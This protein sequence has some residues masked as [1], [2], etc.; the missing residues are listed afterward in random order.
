M[1]KVKEDVP[2]VSDQDILLSLSGRNTKAR[3]RVEKEITRRIKELKKEAGLES[4]INEALE[5]KFTQK[6][7]NAAEPS[8]RILKLMKLLASLRAQA[9]LNIKNDAQLKRVIE[10]IQKVEDAL[11]Q[12]IRKVNEKRKAQTRKDVDFA[13]ALLDDLRRQQAEEAKIADLE[14]IEAGLATEIKQAPQRKTGSAELKALQ[15]RREEVQTEIATR[16][17]LQET[18]DAMTVQLGENPDQKREKGEPLIES[19]LVTALREQI[20]QLKQD[21]TLEGIKKKIKDLETGVKAKAKPKKVERLDIQLAREEFAK[22]TRLTRVEESVIDLKLQ[23]KTGDIKISAP[24]EKEVLSE[25]LQKALIEQKQL[26]RKV[27]ARI[28][29]LAP[30]TAAGLAIDILLTS[31]QL[32][33]TADMSFALRQGLI[34]S[35]RRPVLATK[36]FGRA[37]RAFFSQNTADSI[38]IA[39]KRNPNQF[40]RDKADLFL[41]DIDLG[42]TGREEEFMGRLLANVPVIGSILRASERNMATGLNLLRSAVFDDFIT[43]HPEATAEQRKAYADYINKATGRGSLEEWKISGQLLQAIFFAPRFAVSRIQA[44]LAIVKNFKDPLVRNEIIKDFAALVLTASTIMMLAK[45]AGADVGLD[46][47]DSDFGKI[48]I[49]DTRIDILGGLVQPARVVSL[50]FL[51]TYQIFDKPAKPAKRELREDLKN[52]FWYKTSPAVGI[53]VTLIDEENAIGQ[54]QT[55]A[56]TAL[57]AITPLWVQETYEVAENSKD[58]LKAALAA[59]AAGTGIGISEQ[60]GRKK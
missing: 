9:M 55:A 4:Q 27:N 30:K 57:R 39:I 38:D 50:A 23:L 42:V 28:A 43:K 40:E 26:R 41:S 49:G 53:I 59:L 19:M 45:G 11:N 37:F 48:V 12:N 44:P 36:T 52:F 35:A 60:A 47:D 56:E 32:L 29:G 25:D 3:K 34:L 33:A 46:P 17:Q 31:R 2:D 58:T 24:R 51:K 16:R 15:V 18:I 54:E 1:A 14:A 21:K 6:E 5:G 13:T 10:K 20:A 7:I 8:K 22:L